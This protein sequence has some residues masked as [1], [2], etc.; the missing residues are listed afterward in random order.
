MPTAQLLIY[1]IRRSRLIQCN[2]PTKWN[3]RFGPTNSPADN[4]FFAEVRW[5]GGSRLPTF[6]RKVCEQGW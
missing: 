3:E 6:I 2:I 5:N 1:N 4:R